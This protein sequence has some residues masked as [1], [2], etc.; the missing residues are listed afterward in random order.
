MSS[1]S[2]RSKRYKV[3]RKE[4][5]S[6]F[7]QS[8]LSPHAGLAVDLWRGETFRGEKLELTA[9]GVTQQIYDRAA[10]LFIQ[11][12]AEAFKHQG[13]AMAGIVAPLAFHGIGT[14]TYPTTLTQDVRSLKD[15]L[16][17]QN[18]SGQIWDDL[19]PQA[20]KELREYFPQ[21]GIMEAEAKMDREDFS[22]VGKI[23]EEADQSGRAIQKKLPKPIRSELKKYI[24]DVGNITRNI[25]S[26][27]YLNDK[28]YAQYEK[29]ISSALFFLNL[30]SLLV[31]LTASALLF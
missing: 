28:K 24:L 23:L 25:G 9:G 10:P 18:F 15:R 17:S 12:V 14:Q 20:Q 5:I 30:H 13:L 16:S 21:I 4:V 3:E 22:F 29:D 8:K 6:R 26:G 11:D 19:G 27:W 31:L 7:L 2:S 1:L